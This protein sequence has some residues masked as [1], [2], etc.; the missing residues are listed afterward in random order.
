M[1]GR[2]AI[3][4]ASGLG[5]SGGAKGKVLTALPKENTTRLSGYTDSGK[6][7][8]ITF[9][10]VCHGARVKPSIQQVLPS[11][12]S[13]STENHTVRAQKENHTGYLCTHLQTREKCPKKNMAVHPLS[14]FTHAPKRS[15]TVPNAGNSIAFIGG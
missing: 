6:I 1:C 13:E 10:E 15:P 7:D 14:A 11:V 12:S 2:Y 5:W 9:P 4:G 3:E 8:L